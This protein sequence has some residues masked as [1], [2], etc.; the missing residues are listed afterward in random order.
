MADSLITWEGMAELRAG[1]KELENG[2]AWARELSKANRVI[3]K[4]VASAA[5]GRASGMGHWWGHFAGDISGSGTQTGAKVGVAGE[6]NAAFWG[7]KK[8]TGWH[9]GQDGAPNQPEWVGAGWDVGGPGGPYAINET[10]AAMK[11]QIVEDYGKSIDALTK[12]AFP[13]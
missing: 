10:V 9:A 4:T 11:D 6:A 12:R 13:S 1:L 8:F 3:A 2:A 5:Q 7:A